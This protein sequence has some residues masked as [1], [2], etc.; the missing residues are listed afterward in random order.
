MDPSLIVNQVSSPAGTGVEQFTQ[1]IMVAG[2]APQFF[3]VQVLFL[4][5]D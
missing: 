3:R 2:S 1:E 5:P 4:V